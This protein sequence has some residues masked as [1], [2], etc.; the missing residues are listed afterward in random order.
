MLGK[1]LTW[2]IFLALASF[3]FIAYSARRRM[4][5]SPHPLYNGLLGRDT[6]FERFGFG[7]WE[8]SHELYVTARP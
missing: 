3:L 4:R 5:L 1:L 2:W 8:S 7:F 6:V